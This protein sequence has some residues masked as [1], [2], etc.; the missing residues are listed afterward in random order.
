[1]SL[2]RKAA[3]PACAFLLSAGPASAAEPGTG[4]H[5]VRPGENLHRIAARYLGSA[6]RWPELARLNPEIRNPDLLAPGLR[7]RVTVPGSAETPAAR[8]A[9]LSRKVEAQPTPIPWES[10]R[11]DDLLLD[12]DGLRTASSGLSAAPRASDSRAARNAATRSAA[13]PA[14]TMCVRS[15]CSNIASWFISS[16]RTAV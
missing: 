3:L 1:M 13:V 8:I 9:R 16:R 6:G 10:A 4:W 7:I 11:Q 15:T 12:R 2:L 14:A 5:I